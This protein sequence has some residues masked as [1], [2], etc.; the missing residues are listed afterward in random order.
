MC[1]D[2]HLPRFRFWAQACVFSVFAEMDEWEMDRTDIMMRHK[3]GGGQYGDVYEAIW[4]R[5]N[6]TIAVKTLRVRRIIIMIV[7]FER[8]YDNEIIYSLAILNLANREQ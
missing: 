4:K 2:Y 6:V 5:Y 8:K 7:F 1:F 3:L